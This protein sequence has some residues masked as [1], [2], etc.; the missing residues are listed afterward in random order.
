MLVFPCNYF[1]V[2]SYF[3]IIQ[4]AMLMKKLVVSI[5]GLLLLLS[6]TG[7]GQLLQVDNSSPYNDPVYLIQNIL[8]GSSVVATNVTFNG[9]GALP[10]GANAEMIG[11][12]DGSSSNLSIAEG[13][14]LNTGNINDA[15]GPNNSGSDGID[16]M[17][18][19]DP[20]LDQLSGVV[21][22]NAS[23]IEF[24]FETVTDG[25][26]FKYIFAS[27]EYNEYVCSGYNDA[28]GFFISG[29]DISGP[30]SNN[31]ENLALVPNTGVY[32][33]INTVNN[34]T[35]GMYGAIGG[36]GGSGDPGLNN[37]TYFVDNEALGAQS[38]Q[39]DGFTTVLT[40]QKTL[41][42]CETYHIKMAVADA[43]DG[44]YDSGIFLSKGSLNGVGANNS[45]SSTI[46]ETACGGYVAP[47][48]QAYTTSG[49]YTAVIPNSAGCDST[50]TINLAITLD[51]D[52]FAEFTINQ[53]FGG[54][55]A[56]CVP[57]SALFEDVTTVSFGLVQRTWDFG[58]G[59][60][61]V[62]P[63]SPFQNSPI[64]PGTHPTTMYPAGTTSGLYNYVQHVYENSGTYQVKLVSINPYGCKDSII[65]SIVV[66]DNPTS[67]T[68]AQTA[69]DSFTSP[70]GSY[71]WT[72]SGT[73]LDTIPS[74]IGCD[75]IITINLAIIN[76]SA[77][78]DAQTAC[79]SYTWI[80]GNTYTS[81]N[82]SA[83]HILTNAAGCDSV[84]TLN[85]TINNGSTG[86]DPHTACDSYTWIDGNTYTSNNNTA[87]HTLTN[88][89][90]CDSVVTLNLTINTVD[91]GIN[92]NSP[93][94]TSDAAGAAYQW[95]DCGNNYS[96]IVGETNQSFTATSSGSYA[97]E[98]TQNNCTDTSDCQTV[99]I[100]GLQENK[101][102][103][104]HILPNPT[105][106]ILTI[107]GAEGIAS[108]YDIYGRLV[109]TTNTNILDISKAATGIYFVRVLDEQGEVYVGKLVKD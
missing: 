52:S 60:I 65:R 97:V 94:L 63:V 84:V 95:L 4:Y 8:L 72:S 6:T 2:K 18:S 21:T 10:V 93:T 88:A 44:I 25:I 7:F 78:P 57:F 87:T 43:G 29:P 37:T 39:Y 82:S 36:C 102:N 35:V 9:S 89:A 74:I 28:F 11:Y 42:P 73:Y 109:L 26:S 5:G 55:T 47:D 48:G 70:S 66:H 16:N 30:F 75:S 68:A 41:L 23:V 53:L 61:L 99:T 108:I 3:I 92:N 69:C 71:T 91:N 32:V 12:F 1:L 96:Q 107:E 15:P 83:T 27:E 77:V 67:G 13:V 104:I 40:V 100:I 86:T 80:D 105:T 79:D 20:D 64:P 81:S 101:T 90:G 33:G 76:S 46:T 56:G 31:A 19:G 58:D 14:I 38:V 106:G 98:V 17:T 34:G 54:D 62:S 45:S 24:D 85:L 49:Q 50:I 103:A 51:S 59:F 22:Y